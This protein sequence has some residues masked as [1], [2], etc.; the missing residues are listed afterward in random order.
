M[1]GNVVHLNGV[2]VAHAVDPNWMARPASISTSGVASGPN[3]NSGNYV[4]DGSGNIVKIGARI[5]LYDKV[6]RI[7]SSQV[8]LAGG[9]TGQQGF[10]YDTFGVNRH[11][12]LTPWQ[13]SRIDPPRA[14]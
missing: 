4:Y 5:N 11:E 2:S 14:R 13:A 6:S 7:T 9:G 12:K 8:E 3:W 1:L 10:V